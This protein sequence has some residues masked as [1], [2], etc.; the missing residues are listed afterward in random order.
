VLESYRLEDIS[1]IE[2]GTEIERIY[3]RYP[4]FSH[5]VVDSGG[6][7]ASFIRQWKDSHPQIPAK[8]VKK[9]A[10]SVDMGISIINAD[11]RAGKIYFVEKMCQDLL[12]ELDTVQWD[13]KSMEVGKRVVKKGMSDHAM[14]SFRYGCTKLQLHDSRGFVADD[15]ATHG[16]PEYW[17]R[18]RKKAH[19]Q[20]FNPKPE[21]RWMP[22]GQWKRPGRR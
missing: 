1:T 10:D 22:M 7:G 18:L 19:D 15:T 8:P 5:T 17:A 2:A 4:I 20:A 3:D 14:D 6:Q 13:E 16:S 11:F 12:Q 9:G 21:K